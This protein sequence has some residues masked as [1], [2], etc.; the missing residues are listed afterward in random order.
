[1]F[2][3]RELYHICDC[4]GFRE[5]QKTKLYKPFSCLKG[6]LLKFIHIVALHS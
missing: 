4:M 6:F 3:W 2:N 1:M 5:P